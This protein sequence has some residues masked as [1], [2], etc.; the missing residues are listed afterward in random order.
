MRAEAMSASLYHIENR[1]RDIPAKRA[2]LA[3]FELTNGIS[4]SSNI[5][6]KEAGW[7]L[8]CLN[9]S[10]KQ[11]VFV[12]TPEDCDLSA[13]PFLRMAQYQGATHVVIVPWDDLEDLSAQVPL[14]QNIILIFNMGRSGTTLVSRMFANVPNVLSLSEP[15]AQLDITMNRAENGPALTRA[16]IAACTRLLCR[17]PY[18]PPT[19]TVAFKFYSQILFNCA[20]YCANFPNAKNVFLYRDAL[21]WGNSMQK[22]VMGLGLPEVFSE[23][24]KN[25]SWYMGSAA[26]DPKIL[27]NYFDQS[28]KSFFG[29]LVHA[30]VWALHMEEYM[31][32]FEAGVPFL[33]M[34]YNEI[35]ADHETATK[36]LLKHCGLSANA[37]SDALH[38]FD[39]DSQKGSGIGKDNK[40]EGFKPENYQ[41]FAETLAKH[42]RFNTPDIMLPDIYHPE[43]KA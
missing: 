16:L 6:L 40:A 23:E 7:S 36:I 9:Q 26:S 8:Y 5:I 39:N 13:K 12:K 10:T 35:N 17:P 27:D 29:E 3:N 2:I 25:F 30:P 24:I 15:D 41:R 32:H 22:M 19:E 1:S 11:A 38:G 14:P 43:R 28:A 37:V 31:K 42:P 34:R 20:D 4:V 21:S 18:G 33:A